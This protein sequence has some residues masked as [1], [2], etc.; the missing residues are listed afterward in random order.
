MLDLATKYSWG[1]LKLVNSIMRIIEISDFS[2]FNNIL[3]ANMDLLGI[4]GEKNNECLLI[5][6]LF[7]E[8]LDAS[9][10]RRK[11]ITVGPPLLADAN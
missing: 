7:L 6:F 8:K 1:T 2:N 9:M 10:R 11:T 5:S 4:I 3:L